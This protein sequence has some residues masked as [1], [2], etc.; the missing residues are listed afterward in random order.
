MDFHLHHNTV[1]YTL[2]YCRFT[3]PIK[4][5][6]GI[7]DYI[8]HQNCH[9]I[10][11][12]TV[13]AHRI[14]F[15]R[16]GSILSLLGMYFRFTY[17]WYNY[18]GDITTAFSCRSIRFVPSGCNPIRLCRNFIQRCGIS[19]LPLNLYY[20]TFKVR[21]SMLMAYLWTYLYSEQNHVR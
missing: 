8:C 5:M 10:K 14:N 3:A 18:A 20:N 19:L 12:L 11:I 6:T 7:L 13:L 17:P 16:V 4:I 2:V 9:G 15:Y 21:L 1:M